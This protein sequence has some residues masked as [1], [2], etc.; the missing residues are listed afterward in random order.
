MESL[1]QFSEVI[2]ADR[3]PLLW[4]HGKDFDQYFCRFF[5][6]SMGITFLEFVNQVRFSHVCRDI[7]HTDQSIM[8]ILVRHG[9]T[10]YKLF[11]RMFPETYGCTPSAKRKE[12]S[13][14]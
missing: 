7:L 1:L 3:L 13:G 10:N 2:R 8:E 12:V 6:K 11:R 9:F 14:R 4:N 5:R